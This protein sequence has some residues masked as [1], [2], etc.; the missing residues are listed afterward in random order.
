MHDEKRDIDAD[1]TDTGQKTLAGCDDVRVTTPGDSSK[2]VIALDR[3]EEYDIEIVIRGKDCRS[4]W[5]CKWVSGYGWKCDR[6]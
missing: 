3:D 2:I 5:S 4:I 6:K 1:A